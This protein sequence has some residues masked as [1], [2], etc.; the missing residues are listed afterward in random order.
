[1]LAQGYLAH[2]R[3]SSPHE[4]LLRDHLY[5]VALR[6]QG[7]ASAFGAGDEAYLAGLL[8]D[9]GKG[10]PPSAVAAAIAL[11]M[12]GGIAVGRS[13]I[14]LYAHF[15]WATHG[16]AELIEGSFGR[17]LHGSIRSQ[18]EALGCEVLALGGMPDHVHLVVRTPGKLAPSELA[19]R[20]K[21][22]SSWLAGHHPQGQPGFTWQ[23]GFGVFSLSRKDLPRA[24]A[25]V[26]NQRERHANGT[27]WPSLE[28]TEEDDP[29]GGDRP[30]AD[31]ASQGTTCP[32]A[33]TDGPTA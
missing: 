29:P 2:S 14:A 30:Q 1:M 18:A 12:T 21:G 4:D 26:D 16:R 11:Q 3:R 25:C 33:P 24:V 20:V 23:T 19:Q 28:A 13:K 10:R 32:H 22:A 15:V 7:Y 17:L 6:A 9:L 8:H 31:R 27:T 5:K